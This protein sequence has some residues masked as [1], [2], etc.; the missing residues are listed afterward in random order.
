M[1]RAC[2]LL[3]ADDTLWEN[4]AYFLR[5]TD[6]YLVLMEAHGH[7]RPIALEAFRAAER[8][9]I[10][11]HGY[12]S[13]GFAQSLIMAAQSLDGSERPR[14]E[15]E[16][17][18]LGQW[19]HDHPIEL[20]EGVEATVAALAEH[21]EL[22]IVTKGAPREQESKIR[23]SG[24]LRYVDRYRVLRE[25]DRAAYDSLVA[26]WKLDPS[27]TW[28]VGNSPR[29]DMNP[30][31]AA[32]LRTVYVPHRTLWEVEAETLD[33]LPDHILTAFGE[34]RSLFLPTG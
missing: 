10:P 20:F 32:G 12:G 15:E 25:K 34:L 24:L 6:A 23:R 3:D 22:A 2:L 21:H 4:H 29:S 14:L 1:R 18:R 30:A 5:A 7:T 13:L 11:N 19:I 33:P 28:M 31:K 17:L 27:A 26:E 8:I 16:F 9:R